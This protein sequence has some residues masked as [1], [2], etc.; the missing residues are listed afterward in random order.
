[1][2]RVQVDNIN[3]DVQESTEHLTIK[4]R[5]NL[6]RKSLEHEYTE[7]NANIRHY[8]NLRFAI[9]TVYFAILGGLIVIAF[10]LIP[11]LEGDQTIRQLWARAGGTLV[12]FFFLILERNCETYLQAYVD[13]A[14]E[15]EKYLG[16]N[17]MTERE[18]R[19]NSGF[20]K[21]IPA[22]YATIAIY[23]L[24]LVFWAGLL[25]WKLLH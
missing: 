6:R 3:A 10:N 5:Q 7:V 4:G 14:L 17:Q 11:S 15:L 18:R 8:S 21:I 23:I 12:T 22:R 16:Y 25:I 24:L 13:E 1:M 19:K 20:L 9:F 2:N